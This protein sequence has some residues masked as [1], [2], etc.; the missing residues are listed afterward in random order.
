MEESQTEEP[1]KNPNNQGNHL[2]FHPHV[3][4]RDT[5]YGTL[6]MQH[7]RP[8]RTQ[9]G[10][11]SYHGKKQNKNTLELERQYMWRQNSKSQTGTHP[12]IAIASNDIGLAT[13]FPQANYKNKTTSRV[14]IG[15]APTLRVCVGGRQE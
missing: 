9:D 1:R 8:W 6:T 4:S 13:D 12:E 10:W 7:L 14:R 5:E 3:K 11:E 2:G 15:S